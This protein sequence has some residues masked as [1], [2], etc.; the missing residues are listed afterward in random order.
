MNVRAAVVLPGGG[1]GRR[2]GGARKPFLELAGEPILLHAMRPFL[3]HP[4]VTRVVVALTSEDAA[5]PPAW[6][7]DLDRRLVLCAGGEERVDSVRNALAYVPEDVE[8]ILVHDA[9]RPLVT[10]ALV[11]R[12]LLC[13]A[14]GIPCIAALPVTDT[15]KEVDEG[16]R[17]VATPDRGR[18]W[19]AQ[20]PQAFPRAVLMDAHDRAA[21]EGVKATDDAAL[22]SQYGATVVVVHGEPRN[23]KV[24]TAEDL[25]LAE[26]LLRAPE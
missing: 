23:L 26:A 3:D 2:L 22:V 20:T 14:R 16:G 25:L 18:L 12:T 21:R 8:V 13:A 24:T 7:K 9:A 11:D 17:I 4:C 6:L 10:R 1:R 19:R 5:D 15:I